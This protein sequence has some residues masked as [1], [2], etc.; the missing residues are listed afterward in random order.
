MVKDT[1]GFLGLLSKTMI[2]RLNLSPEM[3]MVSCKT[4]LTGF[5]FAEEFLKLIIGK[6]VH[7]HSRIALIF[8]KISEFLTE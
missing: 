1:L 6:R 2:S 3:F 4:V 5:H 7:C 8:T